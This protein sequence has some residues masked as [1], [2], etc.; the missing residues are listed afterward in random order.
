MGIFSDTR[1]HGGRQGSYADASPVSAPA[2][3]PEQEDF[4]VS[5]LLVL[6]APYSSDGEIARFSAAYEKKLRFNPGIIS[7]LFDSILAVLPRSRYPRPEEDCM[8][9]V[10]S[11]DWHPDAFPEN[12]DESA[13][14]VDAE[15]YL[16]DHDPSF[17]PVRSFLL[18]IESE[19]CLAYC[20]VM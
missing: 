5:R 2:S 7:D 13:V 18:R 9:I 6:T 14:R 17:R 4:P 11:R 15:R 10:T 12:P 1:R 20:M 16:S 19:R 8:E 3:S